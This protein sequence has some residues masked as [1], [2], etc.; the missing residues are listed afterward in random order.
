MLLGMHGDRERRENTCIIT[1]GFLAG[2]VLLI[3]DWTPGQVW[4]LMLMMIA[5]ASCQYMVWQVS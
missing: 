3:L 5:A 4:M 1:A 2:H